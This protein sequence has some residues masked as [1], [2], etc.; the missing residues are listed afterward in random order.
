[1][2][3]VKLDYEWNKGGFGN[4][5]EADFK[6]TNASKWIVKDLEVTCVHTAPSGSEIDRN[7]RT[8]YETI[9]AGG[10]KRVRKFNMGF[11]HSQAQSSACSV[12]DLVLP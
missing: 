1:M 6:F 5:M 11:I 8:I 10:T 9:P 7:T 12:T 3:G 2:A 4:V